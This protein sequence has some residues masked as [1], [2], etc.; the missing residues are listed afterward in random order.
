MIA[1]GEIQTDEYM[2]KLEDYIKKNTQRV[3]S[4]IRY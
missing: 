1:N 2:E 4:R 3:L